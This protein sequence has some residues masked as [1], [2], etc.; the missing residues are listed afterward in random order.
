VP[1]ILHDFPISAPIDRVFRAVSTPTGLDEWWT[2]RASGE[3]HEG[4]EYQL[5]FGPDYDWR[6]RVSR[7]I[8]ATDFELELTHATPDWLGT[9]VGFALSPGAAGTEVRFHHAGWPVLNAHY[10]I[11]C[12]CWAMY[13]RVL[14]RYLEHGEQVPYER[15]LEV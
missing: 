5:W 8:P 11:S 4:A 13:L 3:P 1:D 10:R 7:C 2:K 12:Y 6:A 15:R 14:K 9:R